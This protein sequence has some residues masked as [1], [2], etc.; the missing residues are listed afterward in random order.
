[1]KYWILL[2]FT[3]LL[4]HNL[5]GQVVLTT[6][7]INSGGSFFEDGEMKLSA[8]IGEMTAVHSTFVPS[9]IVTNGVLQP[10]KHIRALGGDTSTGYIKVYPTLLEG[11][12]IFIE[13][14]LSGKSNIKVR[15]L[16]SLGQYLGYWQFKE[17][18]H[19]VQETIYLPV[20]ARGTYYLE[21]TIAESPANSFYERKT[22]KIVK[23]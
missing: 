10:L 23:K 20:M 2:I 6:Q 18:E 15:L 13:L 11:N 21:I 5:Q 12:K 8:N 16:T 7:V 19:L 17:L 4:I 22:F 3:N 1:M 9:L 14:L